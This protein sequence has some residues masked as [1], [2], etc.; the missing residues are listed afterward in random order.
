MDIPQKIVDL[1]Q[2]KAKDMNSEQIEEFATYLAF[3]SLFIG[4]KCNLSMQKKISELE[5]IS[6]QTGFVYFPKRD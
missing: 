5:P 2:E 4:M 1:V 6:D 3:E